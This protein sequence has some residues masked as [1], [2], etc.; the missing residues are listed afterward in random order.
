MVV[1]GTAHVSSTAAAEASQLIRSLCPDVVVIELDAERYASLLRSTGKSAHAALERGDSVAKLVTLIAR[2]EL[3]SFAGGCLY[4]VAGTVLHA[5]PGAEFA[6]AA[7]A[8]QEVGATLVLG[9]RDYRV[10]MSR[11]RHRLRHAAQHSSRD[12]RQQRGTAPDA[13]VASLMHAA[14]CAPEE[15]VK[16]AARR[17][18]RDAVQGGPVQP[19]DLAIVR[20]CFSSVV[21]LTRERA[22][23]PAT[24]QESLLE[25]DLARSGLAPHAADAVHQTLVAERDL[26]LTRSL[27][28]RPGTTVGVVGAGHV[29]GI[30][31]EWQNA[32]SPEAYARAKEYELPV[33][34]DAPPSSNWTGSVGQVAMVG[35]GALLAVRRPRLALRLA[36]FTAGLTAFGLATAA[37]AVRHMKSALDAVDSASRLLDQRDTTT[38]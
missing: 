4:A 36:G 31:R 9:D 10:T 7:A 33:P 18:L 35:G 24:D 15:V 20:Q 8:A 25:L 16:S 22:L 14:H 30:A 32:R 37:Q 11:L 28:L 17:L 26:I 34:S 5:Q 13:R 38:D 2:G 19:D 3:P 27:Q 12:A 6:A 23:V 21:E 29:R 1:L